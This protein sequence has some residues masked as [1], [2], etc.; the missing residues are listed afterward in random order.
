MSSA[1]EASLTIM[2]YRLQ[3]VEYPAP[4]AKRG[5]NVAHQHV[6]LRT[7]DKQPGTACLGQ[8]FFLLMLPLLYQ[9]SNLHCWE[10]PLLGPAVGGTCVPHMVLPEQTHS[11]CQR[12]WCST[13]PCSGCMSAAVNLLLFISMRENCFSVKPEHQRGKCFH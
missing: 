3:A 1:S 12:W 2:F 5:G 6:V 13:R 4:A 8:L 7:G 11:W 10:P 9:H